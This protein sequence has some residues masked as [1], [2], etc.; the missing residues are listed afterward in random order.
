GRREPHSFPP[1]RS[2]DLGAIT[3][4]PTAAGTISS[5]ISATNASGTGS[6]TLTIT[7]GAAGSAPVITSPLSAS[8]QAGSFFSYTITASN[9]PTDRKSTRLNSSHQIIS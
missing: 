5:T 1:R 2:S 3:G 4:A 9:S 8:V 7:V 6:K